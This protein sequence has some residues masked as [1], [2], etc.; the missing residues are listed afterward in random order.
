MKQIDLGNNRVKLLPDEG[1]RL[2]CFL[3]NEYHSEAVTKKENIK[4]FED[5]D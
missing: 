3:D 2:F 4:Y 5:M 1:K